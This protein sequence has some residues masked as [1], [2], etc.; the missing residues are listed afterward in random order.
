VL[1]E[2]TS[3]IDTATEAIIQEGLER[4][5]KS[6]TSV[7]I[8]H[9]LS[10]V[11][12]ADRIIVM[13]RGQIVEEGTHVQLLHADGYYARLHEHQLMH[14]EGATVENGTEDGAAESATIIDQKAV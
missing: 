11:R 3:S 14:A 2:A 5:L 9:R 7:V 10:T 1:D 13:D 12:G 6:R 4:I 8:A